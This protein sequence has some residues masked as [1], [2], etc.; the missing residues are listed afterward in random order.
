MIGFLLF[1]FGLGVLSY[2][3]WQDMVLVSC[4]EWFNGRCKGTILFSR[5]ALQ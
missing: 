1:D 2:L 5:V 4:C 3:V